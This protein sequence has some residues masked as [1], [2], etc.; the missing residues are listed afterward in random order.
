MNKEGGVFKEKEA[1]Q[2]FKWHVTVKSET[3]SLNWYWKEGTVLGG[4]VVWY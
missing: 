4:C 1:E 3:S 2:D